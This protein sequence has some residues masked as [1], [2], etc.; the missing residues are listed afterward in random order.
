MLLLCCTFYSLFSGVLTAIG[1][2]NFDE[3]GIRNAN[4]SKFVQIGSILYIGLIIHIYDKISKSNLNGIR[5]STLLIAYIL[6]GLVS[7]NSYKDSSNIF[8]QIDDLNYQLAQGFK[9]PPRPTEFDHSLYPNQDQ[10]NYMRL[11]LYNLR[12]GPYS[13][14]ESVIRY[15]MD[16]RYGGDMKDALPLNPS[17]HYTQLFRTDSFETH[18]LSFPLVT[19]GT[20]PSELNLEISLYEVHQNI[21][22]LIHSELVS[23]KKVSD[24]QKIHLKN[25]NLRSFTNYELRFSIKKYI[26]NENEI[27]GVPLFSN[28]YKADAF[29]ENNFTY[30]PNIGLGLELLS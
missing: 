15:K 11:Q 3:Y 4:S 19:F 14:S 24:W 21:S 28:K 18:A 20:N 2:V 25:L 9:K 29:K 27:I 16:R 13:D 5:I 23:L 7:F 1:R 10:L 22:T 26:I 6:F 12:L 17:S 30:K 8:L